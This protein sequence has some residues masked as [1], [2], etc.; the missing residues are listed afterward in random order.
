MITTDTTKIL[1]A[2]RPKRTAP[3]RRQYL[4]LL[5]VLLSLS[6][7]GIIAQQ[8]LDIE[9]ISRAQ[10]SASE[11]VKRVAIL[12]YEATKSLLPRPETTAENIL[13]RNLSGTENNASHIYEI[14]ES[15]VGDNPKRRN[16]LSSLQET[17]ERIKNL[18][19]FA[20]QDKN[21]TPEDTYQT[22]ALLKKW[23]DDSEIFIEP[24]REILSESSK[25]LQARRGRLVASFI[26]GSLMLLI[27]GLAIYFYFRQKVEDRIDLVSE[28]ADRL[29]KH[30]KLDTRVT[31]KDN[32]AELDQTLHDI[33]AWLTEARRKERALIDNAV[34][35]ICTVDALEKFETV[36]PSSIRV[37]GYSPEQLIGRSMRAFSADG[38][39]LA[40]ALLDDKSKDHLNFETQ[41]LKPDGS[42]V[43]LLWSAHWSVNQKALFCIAHDISDRKR[44]EMLLKESEERIRMIME[45]IPLGLL[46]INEH[47]AI[48]FANATFQ[49][50]TQYDRE[51]IIGSSITQFFSDDKQTDTRFFNKISKLLEH[52]AEINMTKKNGEVFPVEIS[53]REINTR[54]GR[55]FLT[56]ILDITERQEMDRLKREFVAMITHDLKTP[57]ASLKVTL[58]L[59]GNGAFGEISEKGQKTA[60]R[61]DHQINRLLRM[62][63]DLLDLEK[64]KS[65]KFELEIT[66][67]GLDDI[68][69]NSIE[70][71]RR[72]AEL[73]KIQIEYSSS[74]LF[75]HADGARL[76]QVLVNLLSNAIKFSPA[77]GKIEVFSE[78]LGDKIKTSV[79][80]YGRGIPLE[81]QKSI[82][83]KFEQ[84]EKADS[85]IKGGT[86]LG[87]AICCQIIE[88]HNG[89]LGV[90]SEPDK[91]ST[92]WF[93]LPKPVSD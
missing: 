26:F 42:R 56:T 75:C 69:L 43:D 25:D 32:I 68:I 21:A 34:D 46:L 9:K 36:S 38:R 7:L 23:L 31:G 50:L 15:V 4:L 86:G 49:S 76:I 22:Q 19:H 78:D 18:A 1:P 89:Q 67:V 74:Q 3:A 87:L 73:R 83:Q 93:T 81:H 64:M 14:L 61:A 17:Q 55:R 62:I 84:V 60:D 77:E 90:E 24:E 45:S 65:G 44:A 92:F 39:S 16:A 54:Q 53:M 28:N 30:S 10:L 82:F 47:G 8:I 12:R 70:A 27:S 91:G 41:W 57:L 63:G 85:S 37:L 72:V 40:T 2:P 48:E 51:N 29:Y 79:R 80:D 66:D 20:E 5:P 11:I 59:F 52:S 6:T 88:Q 58:A 33:E 35:V 13:T 71:V